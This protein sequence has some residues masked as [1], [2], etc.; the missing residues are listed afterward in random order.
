MALSINVDR[1]SFEKV[2]VFSVIYQKIIQPAGRVLSWYLQYLSSEDLSGNIYFVYA[3]LLDETRL[4]K[5]ILTLLATLNH[6]NQETI[7]LK[8]W[9]KI[10]SY[11]YDIYILT[12]WTFRASFLLKNDMII[13]MIL[14]FHVGRTN[15]QISH[16]MIKGITWLD[17]QAARMSPRRTRG[18]LLT[19]NSCTKSVGSP[20]I[21][22]D[23]TPKCH[24]FFWAWMHGW[25]YNWT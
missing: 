15:G 6:F 24:P 18:T 20:C 12:F 1:I 11:L 13:T 22:H 16:F 7:R 21:I 4:E 8:A 25:P 19:F 10:W 9:I 17:Q 5:H 2:L 23:R 3:E 14:T